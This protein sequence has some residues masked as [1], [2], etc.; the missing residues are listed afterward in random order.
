MVSAK[1]LPIHPLTTLSVEETNIAR[2]II[3]A[4]HAGSVLHFRI[5]YLQEPPKADL[6]RYLDLEHSGSLKPDSPRPARLARVH[7]DVVD[8]KAKPEFH[9]AVVDVE[10]RERVLVETVKADVHQAFTL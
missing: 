4:C 8:D 1:Q 9:E 5:L 2:D 10:K 7:Y 6:I 3:R